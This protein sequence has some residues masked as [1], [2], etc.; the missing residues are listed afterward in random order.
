MPQQEG[1]GG[2]GGGGVGGGF[3]PEAAP[4]ELRQLC[5]LLLWKRTQ[6][7]NIFVII[8]FENFLFAST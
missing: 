2:G 6:D 7:T 4:L 8:T 1:S 3:G 5:G